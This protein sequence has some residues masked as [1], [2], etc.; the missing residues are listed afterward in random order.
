MLQE[1]VKVGANCYHCGQSC[2]GDSPTIGDKNFCCQGC[3][4]VFEIL[5]ENDLCEYYTFDKNPGTPLRFVRNETYQFL[6]EPA[7]RR[8]VLSFD[9][10]TFCRVTFFIPAIHCVSCIWLLENLQRLNTSI[11]QSKVDF[12]RKQV[13]IDYRADAIPLSSVA[14]LVA[15]M[16]Y[17]PTIHLEGTSQPIVSN[18]LLVTQIAIAGF[19][20]ANIMLLSFPEYLG[21][22]EAD[23]Q[24]NVLFSFL[25]LALAVPAVVY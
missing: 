24:L 22:G 1:Q 19:C 13:T 18:N 14:Q 25:N 4:T 15:S 10:D 20:F 2:D 16:G 7:I 11:L 3:K 5:Y 21:L 23:R 8:K 6:D 12:S 17:V 9:S